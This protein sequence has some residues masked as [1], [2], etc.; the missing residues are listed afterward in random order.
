MINAK[1]LP[2]P[3][4]PGH[5]SELSRTQPYRWMTGMSTKRKHRVNAL[6]L[7]LKNDRGVLPPASK[8]GIAKCHRTVV[9][10]PSRKS[11]V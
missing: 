3:K 11:F 7:I 1:K 4:R 10:P 6:A 8:M 9:L 5:S 2:E